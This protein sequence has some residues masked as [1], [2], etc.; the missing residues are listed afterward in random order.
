MTH[1][2]KERL[3]LDLLPQIRIEAARG[4]R[5]SGYLAD[6]LYQEACMAAWTALDHFDESRSRLWTFISA[7]I[8]WRFLTIWRM[9]H[10]KSRFNPLKPEQASINIPDYRR[11]WHP[12]E[13]DELT[14]PCRPRDREVL[15]AIYVDGLTQDEIGKQ[16]GVT[17]QCIS[18]IHRRA[19]TAIRAKD[20]RRE[21]L[22]AKAVR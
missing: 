4:A 11:E 8:Q 19:L 20:K 21:L 17:H 5:R 15:R 13:F 22:Q 12:G 18:Q 9:A 3:L 2:E 16:Q 7:C 1:D 14:A 10:N 6:D